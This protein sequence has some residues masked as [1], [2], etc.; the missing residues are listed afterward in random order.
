MKSGK[1]AERPRQ[2]PGFIG[3]VLRVATQAAMAKSAISPMETGGF[4]QKGGTADLIPPFL[5]LLRAQRQGRTP[6]PEI[7][8]RPAQVLRTE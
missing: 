8:P 7:I 6:R 3:I 4:H 2:L 5:A 1:I